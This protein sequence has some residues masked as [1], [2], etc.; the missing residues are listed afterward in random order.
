MFNVKVL[1]L[2]L[3]FLNRTVI[4]GWNV[5]FYSSASVC[6][7]RK[8]HFTKPDLKKIASNHSGD[9][10]A[11]HTTWT[12]CKYEDLLLHKGKTFHSVHSQTCLIRTY[13]I[14]IRE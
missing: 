9:K 14:Q 6:T 10:K 7:G 1:N 11:T 4:T 8:T 13:M 3:N 12:V 5:T 2:T